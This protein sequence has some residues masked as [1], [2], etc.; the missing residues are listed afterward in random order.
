MS[1]LTDRLNRIDERLG[2]RPKQRACP[3][4][5]SSTVHSPDCPVLAETRRK[6]LRVAIPALVVF[7]ALEFIYDPKGAIFGWL[8]FIPACWLASV[9]VRRLT[10]SRGN[11]NEGQ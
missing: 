7:G 6:I 10:R 8:A 3:S 9:I 5:G 1:R 11:S 4:C 2:F